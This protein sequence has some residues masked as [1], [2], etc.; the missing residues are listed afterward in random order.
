MSKATYPLKLPASIEAAAARPAKQDGVSLNQWIATAVA[1]KIGAVGTAA[2][3]IKCWA[4]DAGPEILRRSSRAP[5]MCHLSLAM[6]FRIIFRPG[7][8][9]CPT[10]SKP[11]PTASAATPVALQ[12]GQAPRRTGA[13][14]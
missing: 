5:R 14:A 7:C 13:A 10:E 6:K 2:D 4:G 11:R 8:N 12:P 3:F 1:R 9:E